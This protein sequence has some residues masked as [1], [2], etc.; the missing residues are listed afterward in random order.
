MEGGCLRDSC[1]QLDQVR[2]TSLR[3]MGQQDTQHDCTSDSPPL[4]CCP[5]YLL[6]PSPFPCDQ[7]RLTETGLLSPSPFPCDQNRLTEA[8]PEIQI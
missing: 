4:A 7:N 8:G 3:E 1:G 5:G 2:M 6:S